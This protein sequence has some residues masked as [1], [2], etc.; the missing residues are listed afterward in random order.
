MYEKLVVVLAKRRFWQGSRKPKPRGSRPKG[1]KR[2]NHRTMVGGETK[3]S[4]RDAGLCLPVG[5]PGKPLT[6]RRYSERGFFASW[7]RSA[8][9]CRDNL[10]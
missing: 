8:L 10:A 3:K 6:G 4:A 1:R 9:L 7:F 5:R 2:S